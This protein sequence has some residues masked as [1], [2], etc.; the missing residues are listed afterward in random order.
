M[1]VLC[2]ILLLAGLT[3][4]G[5]AGS[6]SSAGPH[7]WKVTAGGSIEAQALQAEKFLPGSITINAG[8]SITWT[9]GAN[10]HTVYFPGAAKVPDF[11]V[12][13]KSKGQLLFNSVFYYPSGKAYNGS[14]PFSAGALEPGFRMS[15]TVT[16]TKPGTYTYLCAFHP[17][18][19]GTVVVQPAGS[20]YPKTQAEYDALARQE[21]Q[22]SYE[23]GRVLWSKNAAAGVR[24]SD[25]KTRY[26]ITLIGARESRFNS[27][28][29]QPQN[30]SIKTGDSVTWKTADPTDIHTVTFPSGRTPDLELFQSNKTVIANPLV[31]NPAGDHLYAGRGYFNSGIMDPTDPQAVHEYTLKFTAP[32][33]FTYVC[34]VHAEFG[35]DGTITVSK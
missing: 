11:V 15:T 31:M 32:G 12:P 20:V 29:F 8:D 16:F 30:L 4:L 19:E 17:G 23:A 14:G 6:T 34:V 33:R 9:L 13:G 21:A 5:F 35:M 22:S 26:T 2:S 25:G 18:M 27:L 24:D 7:A 1:R 10:G 3:V 28:R